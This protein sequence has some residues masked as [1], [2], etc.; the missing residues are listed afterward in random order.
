MSPQ[1]ARFS[2]NGTTEKEEPSLRNRCNQADQALSIKLAQLEKRVG[3]A[4]EYLR[5]LHLPVGISVE[6]NRGGYEQYGPE[7][8]ELLGFVRSGSTWRLCYA[9]D[10]SENEEQPIWKPLVECSTTIRLRALAELGKLKIEAVAAKERFV[11]EVG[12]ALQEI[13]QFL[14]D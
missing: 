6:Y 4:E 1:S 7:S 3:D 11:A 8:W 5:S 14:A 10:G 2:V 9:E 12:D 13:D